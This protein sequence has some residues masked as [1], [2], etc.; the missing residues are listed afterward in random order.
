M[1]GGWKTILGGLLGIGGWVFGQPEITPDVIL[2]A[3]GGIL[4]TVGV[5]HAIAKGPSPKTRL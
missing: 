2:T 5:R 1:F 3:I 4:G